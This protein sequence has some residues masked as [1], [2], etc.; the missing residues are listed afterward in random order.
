[1]IDNWYNPCAQCKTAYDRT[2]PEHYT[3]S[4]VCGPCV[5]QRDKSRKDAYL[6]YVA[7]DSTVEIEPDEDGD[8]PATTFVSDW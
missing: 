2:H 1:M 4:P 7:H 5:R 6:R 3:W 8:W